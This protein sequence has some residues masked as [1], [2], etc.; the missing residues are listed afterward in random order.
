M[1]GQPKVSNLDDLQT[2]N[3]CFEYF[4]AV[5]NDTEQ[6]LHFTLADE[7]YAVEILRVQEIKGWKPVTSIPNSPEHICGVLN[8]RS[9]IV[10]I[11]DLR[12]YFEMP[13]KEYHPET[14][15]IVLRVEGV[16]E[17]T[18]GIVVDSVLGT[19]N[20]APSSIKLSPDLGDGINTAF[21]SGLVA[22][23]DRMMML[24]DIDRLL[25]IEA[26]G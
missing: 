15:V 8:F 10:P 16:S 17:R 13:I 19:H 20:V 1:S 14:I 9:K 7:D 18:V 2:E 5:D 6:Y 4:A 11:V 26:L 23:D 21:I 22:V 24:L 12:R 25:S 3:E